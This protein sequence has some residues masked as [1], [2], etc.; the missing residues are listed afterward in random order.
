MAESVVISIFLVLLIILQIKE[1]KQIVIEAKTSYAKRILAIVLA[2]SLLVIFWPETLAL[3]IKLIAVALMVLSFAFIKE[4]VSESQLVKFG[5]L[6]SDFEKYTRIEI[7]A[8]GNNQSFITFYKNE[9][10]HFSMF[11]NEDTQTM[12]KYFQNKQLKQVK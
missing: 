11:F 2:I 6:N 10:T 8:Y 1:R 5:L 9:N 12:Q 4:G 3:Q 7:E